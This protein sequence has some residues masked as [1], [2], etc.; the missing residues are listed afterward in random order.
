MISRSLSNA[1]LLFNNGSLALESYVEQYARNINFKDAYKRLTHVC[2]KRIK[3]C[4]ESYFF[5]L[6]NYV[7]QKTRECI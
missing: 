1:F 3:I 5:T 7:F 4:M 2:M 6:I